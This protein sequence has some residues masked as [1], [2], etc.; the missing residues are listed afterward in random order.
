MV[1]GVSKDCLLSSSG[2]KESKKIVLL[3]LLDP[4]RDEDATILRNVWNHLRV[5][6]LVT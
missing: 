5:R 4:V 6:H 2:V 1:P 3:G